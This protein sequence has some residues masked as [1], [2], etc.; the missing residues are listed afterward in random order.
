MQYQRPTGTR[1]ILPD[2]QAYWRFIIDRIHHVAALYGYAQI[3]T[4]IFE[5][6]PVFA[7]GVGEST[8]I[9]QKEM[10]TF[11][12]QG[13]TSLT[14]RPEYTAGVV[15]AYL[16]NG[17]HVWPQPVKLY[18]IGPVFRHERPQANRY[19]QIWQFNA[20]AIGAQDPA[21]DLEII[22]LARRLYMELG[23]TELSFQINSTGCPR[24]RPDYVAALADHFEQ[25]MDRLGEDDRR[26]LAQN[27]LRILD[28][29]DEKVQPLVAAAPMIHDYLCEECRAHFATL[30][31]Y[32]D[33]L[34]WS[35][36]VNPRLV[37]GLDYYT[38]TVFEVWSAALGGAQSAL[39]GGGRYDGLVELLGGEP[40][41]GVGYAAGIDRM[42][43]AMQ[44]LDVEPPPLPRPQVAV[45]YLGQ[46]AKLSAIELVSELRASDISAVMFFDDPSMRSQMRSANREDVRY[47]VILGERELEQ[48]VAAVK[49]MARDVPQEM[50][51]RSELVAWLEARL[52]G[53][54]AA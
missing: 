33:R 40:T 30:R 45:I 22:G 51:D 49:D 5:H 44:E 26:R 54:Q 35:Y 31:S 29:K 53:S 6:T 34:G 18:S 19:R 16:E 36:T 21:V 11:E 42:V 8:D 27:P 10:Y 50:V 37:R 2:E 12:D 41:P 38:K 20:E 15:R 28:T 24:C 9:V 14:L 7:R 39:T 48:G 23:I 4:P 47:A 1:D 46:P 32:L 25:Y 52:G 3:R 13:G 17:M 43:T